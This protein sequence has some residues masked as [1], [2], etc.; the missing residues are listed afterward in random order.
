[1]G[2]GKA[3][4]RRSFV[5]SLLRNAA[6]GALFPRLARAAGAGRGLLPTRPL[7]RTGHQVSLF[8][9]G[10]QALLEDGARRDEAVALIHRALDLGVN[11]VDTASVYGGGASELAIGEVM[12]TRRGEVFLASKTHDRSYDGSMRLLERSLRRL[13]TDRLDAWQ[14]H[15]VKTDTDLDFAFSREGAV[16]A[17]ESA[18]GQGLVRFTGVTGH[19]DPHV[20]RRAIERYPFDLALLA[21][22]AAD[23]HDASFI[24]HA[25]PAAVERGLAVVGMK[26][27]GRGKLLRPDGVRTMEQAMRYALSLPVHTV[28]VGV[29]T[30]AELE[31][32]VAIARAFRPYAPA[33]M[34]ELERLTAHYHGEALWYRHGY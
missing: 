27:P 24:D 17:L 16:R 29:S 33:E 10:G 28:I 9:L 26:I 19:Q 34:R 32:D 15:N 2:T 8:G 3:W 23:R 20:I 12:R 14:L 6:F 21:L 4:S 22:N 5:R 13:G 18:R 7:G 1:M 30:L 25:L 11:Y 31:E